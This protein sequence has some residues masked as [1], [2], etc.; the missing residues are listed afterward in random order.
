MK[1]YL[2]K[3]YENLYCVD[4]KRVIS[5]VADKKNVPKRAFI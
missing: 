4:L 2:Q 1:V 3:D 5:S